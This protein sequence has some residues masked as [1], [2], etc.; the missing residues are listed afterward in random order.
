MNIDHIVQEIL[1]LDTQPVIE[2]PDALP[3][4]L[5]EGVH[6]DLMSCAD[7]FTPTPRVWGKAKQEFDVL[8]LTKKHQQGLASLQT[9]HAIYEYIDARVKGNKRMHNTIIEPWAQRYW[10][11]SVGITAHKDESSKKNYLAIFVIEGS[12]AFGHAATREDPHPQIYEAKPGSLLLLRAPQP[13]DKKD[14]RPFHFVN[15]C[16]D[17]RHS[18]VYR[19]VLAHD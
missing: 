16:S 6:E 11:G 18:V 2:I 17:R 4:W 14:H 3:R 19:Q 10:Q 12:A 13:Y 1:R 9:L 8:H 5:R 15:P 7:E